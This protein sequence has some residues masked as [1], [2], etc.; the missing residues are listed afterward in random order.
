ME[1]DDSAS[2]STS[3]ITSHT[4]FLELTHKNKIKLVLEFYFVHWS[5]TKSEDYAKKLHIL[6]TGRSTSL[7]CTGMEIYL[8][9][10][11]PMLLDSY[12][13][14]DSCFAH[15]KFYEFDNLILGKFDSYESL[16]QNLNFYVESEYYA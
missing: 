8:I 12:A 11:W 2:A 3:W 1:I 7:D 4:N 9:D 16:K 13:K 5:H 6:M 10:D 14:S 15:L